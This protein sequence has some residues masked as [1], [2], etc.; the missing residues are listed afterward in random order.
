MPALRR[1]ARLRPRTPTKIAFIGFGPAAETFLRSAAAA[2][3][4]RLERELKLN[5][6]T[7]AAVEMAL[8]DLAGKAAGVPIYQLLGGKV[9][10]RMPIKMVVLTRFLPV[11]GGLRRGRKFGEP[12]L[13]RVRDSYLNLPSR[14][15]PYPCR[16][17]YHRRSIRSGGHARG[18]GTRAPEV[19]KHRFKR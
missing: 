3:T 19:R 13:S 12:R 10:E 18:P 16:L 9:R 15:A 7:R 6:F 1:V 2:G 5:P 17:G 14:W 11:G 4:L 8:W